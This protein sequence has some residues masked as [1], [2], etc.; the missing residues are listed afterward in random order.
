[1][2]S[3]EE[4]MR[5]YFQERT[6]MT[7]AEIVRRQPFCRRLYAPNCFWDSRRNAIAESE[8]ERILSVSTSE[9]AAV[10]ITIG[11]Y[12]RPGLPSRVRYH[13][14]IHDGRWPIEEAEFDC[15]FCHGVEN[16]IKD[17]QLCKGRGWIS[18]ERSA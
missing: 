5:E 4:F 12:Q 1:M 11:M 13:L 10:V 3:V 15:S 8:S 16:F 2:Q 7:R 9:A 14:N 6:D 18:Y 17:C